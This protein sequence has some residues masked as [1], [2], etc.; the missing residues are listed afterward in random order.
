MNRLLRLSICSHVQNRENILQ[1]R[2][3]QIIKA[4]DLVYPSPELIHCSVKTL[5]EGL[6]SDLD[7]CQNTKEM[8]QRAN[9]V[10]CNAS[11]R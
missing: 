11:L 7:L 8:V 10:I 4:K 3:N 5:L 2:K 1:V 6:S 9:I